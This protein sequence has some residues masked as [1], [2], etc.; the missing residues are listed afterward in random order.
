MLALGGFASIALGFLLFFQPATGGLVLTLMIGAYALIFGTL[1]VGL[2]IR[3]RKWDV[4]PRN[5]NQEPI[6][7]PR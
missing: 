2:G 5:T 1:L 4:R 6:Q 7:F 3:L